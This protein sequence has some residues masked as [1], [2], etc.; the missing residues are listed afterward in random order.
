M[1]VNEWISYEC[2][3]EGPCTPNI[4]NSSTRHALEGR[5]RRR[6]RSKITLKCKRALN[7]STF[8]FQDAVTQEEL[9]IL[10]QNFW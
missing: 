1:D 2:S 9:I 7:V 10:I 8:V 6:N 3:D 4:R 5:N